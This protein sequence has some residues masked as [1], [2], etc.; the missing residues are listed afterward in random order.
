MIGTEDFNQSKHWKDDVWEAWEQY[1][2]KQIGK[3]TPIYSNSWSEILL[4][5]HETLAI[6][7]VH[8]NEED[9][10]DNMSKKST[11]VILKTRQ[12]E[13]TMGTT[14]IICLPALDASLSLAERKSYIRQ[15]VTVRYSEEITDFS[16]ETKL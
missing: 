3:F 7:E 13:L 10:N 2:T 5:Q 11:K 16:C 1:I 12:L 8:E 6:Q 15:Y 9:D 4:E 14:G